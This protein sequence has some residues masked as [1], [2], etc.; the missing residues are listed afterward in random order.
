MVQRDDAARREPANPHLRYQTGV[1]R[2]LLAMAHLGQGD[3]AR[4]LALQ[5]EAAAIFRRTVATDPGNRSVQRD[6]NL[7]QISRGRTLVTAGRNAEAQPLLAAVLAAMPAAQPAGFDLQRIR[8]EGLL[9]AARAWR[10][11]DA[12]RAL[13]WAQQAGV[14]MRSPSPADSNATRRWTLAQALGEQAA[15]L[16]S[17][18]R[19]AEARTAALQALADWQVA[20]GQ[21]AVWAARD[22]QLVGAL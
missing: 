20:P 12:A 11:T 9:W 7:L 14:L 5:D 22:R 2:V 16:A 10:G 13:V 17:L 19:P 21:F 15:A 3:V 4:S 8:A 18:G 6:L 1:A